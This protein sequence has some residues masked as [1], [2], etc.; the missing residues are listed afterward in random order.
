MVQSKKNIQQNY[1]GSNKVIF[2]VAKLEIFLLSFILILTINYHVGS[3]L[4]SFMSQFVPKENISIFLES[5]PDV[6]R[7]IKQSRRLMVLL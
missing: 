6:T 1:I 5:I 7:V 4:L 2:L 3:K